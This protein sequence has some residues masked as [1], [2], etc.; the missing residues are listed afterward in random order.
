VLLTLIGLVAHYL[1]ARGARIEPLS[2]LRGVN[3]GRYNTHM[4]FFTT[5][6]A[7]AL[8][9]ATALG[10]PALA[11]EAE[12]IE[13]AEFQKLYADKQVLVVDVRDE[14]SFDNGHIP[15]A[16]NIPLGTED[17]RILPLK[18]EKR[19]IVTYCA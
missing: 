9:L 12:R 5:R 1:P 14:G 18:T 3:S 6:L 15:G 4:R 10:V 11:Q 7:M 13:L 16:I 19:P 8:A 17:H 2:G